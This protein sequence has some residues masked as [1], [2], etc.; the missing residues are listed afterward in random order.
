MLY[1]S[2]SIRARLVH[3]VLLNTTQQCSCKNAT[4]TVP[5]SSLVRADCWCNN[6]P[7]CLSSRFYET[8][9]SSLM[10][11]IL[12]CQSECHLFQNSSLLRLKKLK[13]KISL[14]GIIATSMKITYRYN[15]YV[16]VNIWMDISDNMKRVI[17]SEI[18]FD[19]WLHDCYK[20]VAPF[21]IRLVNMNISKRILG[22]Y[23]SFC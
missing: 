7:C 5:E 17:I 23:K 4:G 11:D 12:K 14:R 18:I 19:L 22:E 1:T 10:T 15:P 2:L 20:V 8:R 9:W 16:Y 6:S 3:D 21:F 13:K